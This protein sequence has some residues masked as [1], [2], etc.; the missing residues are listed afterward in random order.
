MLDV[1]GAI[2]SPLNSWLY[3]PILLI[4]LLGVGIYFT[5][6]S[7]FLQVRLLGEAFRVTAEKPERE[8]D[9]SSFETLMVTTAS[10]VGTG[11]IVG[12]ASAICLGG[13]GAIFWMWVVAVIGGA[14]AF[15][16]STLAQIYKR[17]DGKGGCYGGPS[18]YIE[19][20]LKSRVIGVIFAVSLIL[21]Y[22]VGFNMLAAFNLQTSF[23]VYSFY[24]PKITPWIIGAILAVMTGYCLFGGGKRILKVTSIL[25][26]IMGVIY[27][28]VSLVMVFMNISAMPAIFARIFANAFN[29]RAIFGG[30]AGSCLVYG[31]KR[32]LYSNEAG[33]GSA[34]NAAATAIVSHP[35]K[36]G[37]VQMLSVFLDTL[38]ICSAT[39]FMCFSAGIEPSESLSGAP[40][41]QAALSTLMGPFGNHFIT[42][43]LILFAF[44]T[45]LGNLYYVD[46]NLAYI[47]GKVPSKTFMQIYRVLAS[48]IVFFGA[49]QKQALAWDIG[50]LL[51]G[52]MALINLPAIFLL[53]KTALNALKD[54]EKQRKAGK[55]PVFHAADIGMKEQLDFWQ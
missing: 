37:L 1:L 44:T 43:S 25:V 12:V 14:S 24:D 8:G 2:I 23:T 53:G 54:Y 49:A 7:G 21:T 9:V 26:P 19:T 15:I 22:A 31:I 29:F 42:F 18:Y 32:G 30:V 45:L 47:C 16:E 11:N 50:D 39:A 3:Y 55:E 5:I 33:I 27:I 52:I 41:V 34:P 4:L 38:I 6:R 10:R 35:V 46:D 48:L 40:Y 36:Q 13:H 20:A 17:S 51:M 28:L